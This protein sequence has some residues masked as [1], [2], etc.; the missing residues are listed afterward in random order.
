[1][2]LQKSSVGQVSNQRRLRISEICPFRRTRQEAEELAVHNQVY[3]LRMSGRLQYVNIK[4]Y[5]VLY[6]SFMTQFN[7]IITGHFH[8]SFIHKKNSIAK[9]RRAKAQ[10]LKKIKVND[11]SYSNEKMEF[12]RK[13]QIKENDLQET[14]CY[15]PEDKED[16]EEGEEK[17]EEEKEFFGNVEAGD[18]RS[19]DEGSHVEETLGEFVLEFYICIIF[20]P[21]FLHFLTPFTKIQSYTNFPQIFRLT[22][23][24]SCSDQVKGCS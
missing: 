13:E 1:M 7:I 10:E 6:H 23:T 12:S 2:S 24:W 11:G 20:D 22:V 19:D 15:V 5:E 4:V 3:L 9:F 17:E 16:E 18:H 8:P 21:S 14:F